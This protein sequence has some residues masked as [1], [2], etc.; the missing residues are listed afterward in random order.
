MVE[1]VRMALKHLED[2]FPPQSSAFFFF[3]V[4]KISVK[5]NQSDQ[6]GRRFESEE[7]KTNTDRKGVRLSVSAEPEENISLPIFRRK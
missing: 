4:E 3:W 5:K 1:K 2:F 6:S 7:R